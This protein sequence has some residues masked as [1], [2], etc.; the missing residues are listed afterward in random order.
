MGGLAITFGRNNQKLGWQANP[1]Y[2][3]KGLGGLESRAE[4]RKGRGL[5][6][7]LR[8]SQVHDGYCEATEGDPARK[9]SHF[10]RLQRLQKSRRKF[11][12][13]VSEKEIQEM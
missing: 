1:L 3:Q 2:E 12:S 8:T 5:H 4:Q 6:P 11:T 7:Y 9:V 10:L 13:V